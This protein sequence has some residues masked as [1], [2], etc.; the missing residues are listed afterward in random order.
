MEFAVIGA[1]LAGLSCARLLADAGRHVEIF[2]KGR[3]PGGRVATRRS[4]HGPF[5]HGAPVLD[6]LPAD[7]RAL[8]SDLLH[9]T[10]DGLV[11]APRMS[12]LPR[13]MTRTLTVHQSSRLVAITHGQRSWSLAF[14][15][16][17][18]MV[19][20]QVVLLCIPP[21]QVLELLPSGL[22]SEIGAARMAP[23]WTVML[24]YGDPVDGPDRIEAETFTALRMGARPDRGAH[25]D[26]W[27]VHADAAWSRQN[28][29]MPR[30]D[31]GEHL[32]S[33]F[34]AATA[35]DRP[36]HIDVHRWLYGRTA[37]PAGR[38]FF[39]NGSDAIGVAGDWCLGPNAGHAV[40]SGR[41]LAR[42]IL[43]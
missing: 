1:G 17:R 39:W 15:G 31:V 25:P 19:Q 7:L 21:Q 32:L 42:E 5:D 41:A 9:D 26:R 14:D 30:E 2:D 36:D 4:D 23:L 3:G 20:A 38:P 37:V 29:D 8:H 22:F 40:E 6:D 11:A 43:G 33:D 16:A 28:V 10:P 18:G 34:R 12:A 35:A 24:S 13:A 27:V